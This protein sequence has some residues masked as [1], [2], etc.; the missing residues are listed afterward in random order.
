LRDLRA[1]PEEEAAYGSL[2]PTLWR[3]KLCALPERSKSSE[4]MGIV[5]GDEL[6]PLTELKSPE[7]LDDESEMVSMLEEGRFLPSS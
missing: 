1:E 4:N 2:S 6:R 3:L 5:S 7:M